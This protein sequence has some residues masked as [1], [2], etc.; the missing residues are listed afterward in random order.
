MLI[1]ILVSGYYSR[2]DMKAPVRIGVIAL[3]TN[4][5]LNL[6]LYKPLG[7]VGLALAT[8]LAAGLNAFL[9]YRGLRKN[10][11]YQPVSGWLVWYGRLIVSCFAMVAVLWLLSQPMSVWQNWSLTQRIMQLTIEISSA[12]AVYLFCLYVFGLR[13]S[14]LRHNV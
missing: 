13:V 12:I 11:T 7:H 1:K 4:I 5:I 8:S 10:K 3:V 9:L 6:A 2:Q 14:H